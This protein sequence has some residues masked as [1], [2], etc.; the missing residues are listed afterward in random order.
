M[1]V[2]QTVANAVMEKGMGHKGE[3]RQTLM[4]KIDMNIVAAVVGM[5]WDEGRSNIEQ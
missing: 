4:K 2:P 1:W 5:S 3:Q